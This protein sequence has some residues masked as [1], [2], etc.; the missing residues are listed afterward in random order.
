MTH[1]HRSVKPGRRTGTVVTESGEVVTPPADWA[2]LAPGDGPLT[3]LVKVKGPT[4]I[5]QVKIGR[6]TISQGIWAQSEHIEN[7]RRELEVKRQDPGY[8]RRRAQ[9]LARKEKKHLEYVQEFYAEVVKFLDFHPR[10]ADV[11]VQLARAVAEHAT[12]VGSGTVARTER[13]SLAD[14]ARAAV[15]AWLRHQTTDY[16]RMAIAR[17]KGRRR[18]VRREL[19]A[20]SMTLLSPYRTGDD[21]GGACSLQQALRRALTAGIANATGSE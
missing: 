15:V 13:I 12:P 3:R 9:E 1:E 5:V 11:A 14:R 17:V 10:H 7:A 21:V 18:E 4:W 6:R 8:D 20:R 19:A 2:L 16:D